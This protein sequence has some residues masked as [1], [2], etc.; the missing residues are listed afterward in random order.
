[1]S[2]LRNSPFPIRMTAWALKMSIATLSGW[3]KLFDPNL[4]PYKR[5]EKRGKSRKVTIEIVRSVVTKAKEIQAEGG[6]IRIKQFC[7]RVREELKIDLGRK[8]VQEILIA[9]DL[10][11]SATRIRRPRFYRNICRRIPNSL[12]SLD[13]SEF[14]VTIDGKPYTFNLELGVDVGS[15]CHTGFDIRRTETAQAVI[16]VLER[17]RRNYGLPLGV[18]FDHGSA[19]L[20]NE[21]AKWLQKHGVEKVPVG[22]GNPKG[23]GTDEGAFS[24]LKNVFGSL[25]VETFS[26]EQLGKDILNM[27]V[28]VYIK[29]RN[30]LLLRRSSRT[31]ETIM[32]TGSSAQ[33]R[34]HDK[35]SILAH[36]ESKIPSDEEQKNLDCLYTVIKQHD[37][38]LDDASM[39]RAELTIKQYSLSAIQKTE[40]AFI[41]AVNRKPDRKNIAY[42]F[43]IL[44]N[45]QQEE[46]DQIYKDYCREKYEYLRMLN[47][48]RQEQKRQS[49]KPTIALV[50][51]MALSTTGQSETVQDIAKRKCSEWL[52]AIFDT[53]KYGAA[54]KKRIQEQIGTMGN[55][56]VSNKEAVWEWIAP[57]LN[58]NAERGSVTSFS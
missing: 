49:S 58:V 28:S 45:I 23:N 33:E 14:V 51:E 20:S 18:L 26:P 34:Q 10:Y 54:V 27:L 29:M 46:D 30:Q 32:E 24:Q 56:T 53:A 48:E 35:E 42:F 55:L 6:R 12:L 47:D 25:K 39:K 31:P 37:L 15:F 21:V 22:P 17:H 40:R 44:K 38:L 50:V 16:A 52:T 4:V 5:P 7:R 43:G 19:N 1:V 9:N 36:K 13:G 11:A 41:E 8:T 57:L 3:D 2:Y